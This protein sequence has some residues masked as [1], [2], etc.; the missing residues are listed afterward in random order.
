M[1]KTPNASQRLVIEDLENNA[2]VFAS[3]GT[4]KTFTVAKRVANILSRGLAKAEEILCLTFT[5][6][7]CNEM[8][9][10]ICRYVDDASTAVQVSTIHGFCYKLLLE[11][12]KRTG[13]TYSDLDVCDEVDQEE[14]AK[15]ILSEGYPLWQ[16]EKGLQAHDLSMPKLETLEICRLKSGDEL[17]WK[18]G[19]WLLSTEGTLF[20]LPPKEAFAPVE[21]FC[22]TCK[23]KRVL[24]DNRCEV[25]GSVHTLSL[26]TKEFEV[27][28]K[29]TGLRNL[30][31]ELKH[32]REEA[33]LYT[34][35]AEEDYARSLAYLRTEK[36]AAYE[37]LFAYY[38]PYLGY[39]PDE[40]FEEAM[41]A[42]V[43]KW[44]AT[45]DEYLR[46]SNLLDFDDLILQA[47][48]ILDGEEGF[49]YWS[50]KYK[51]I[52]LDEMQ[53]TS[54]LEYSLLKKIFAKNNVLLCG[55][56]FQTIYGWRGSRPLEILEEYTREFSAK[57]Y[58]LSENY[59]A[60]KTLAEATFG[61]LKNTYPD[62]MG[63]FC[64]QDLR[65]N[66]QVEGEPIF[67]YAFD[68]REQEAW[69]IYKYLLRNKP[70]D[71]L[72]TC[73]I[74]RSN[75]YIAELSAYF[76]RFAT[77]RE[78][79]DN[80]RF[81]T[82]EE[83]V[84]FFKKAVVKDVLAV[85]KLLL[86]PYDRVSMERLA[87]KYVRQV[88]VKTLE[89][90]RQYNE[91]GISVC[92]FIDEQTYLYGDPYF[93]LLE[94][95]TK[96]QIVVYD[97]ETTGL[98]LTKDEIVQLSAIK[99]NAAGETV[100]TID[101]WI[102]PTVPLEEGA[103]RTHGF[104]LETIRQNGGTSAKE[105]L[106]RFADFCKG[107][108]LVG[109]N[110]LSYDRPLLE[111][112]LQEN[113]LPPIESVGEYDTLLIAKQ[114]RPQLENYK[115]GTLC[116]HFSVVNTCAHNALGDIT[117]TGACLKRLVD[118]YI[119]PTALERQTVLA[120]HREKFEKFFAF[121]QELRNKLARREPL[122]S[123]I[124]ERL[125]LTTKYPTHTDRL[126]LRDLIESLETE[127][128][129]YRVFLKEYLK[130]AALSG[131]QMDVLLRKL[132]RIPIITVHQS[133]GCEFD[134]VILAGADDS[135]FP[136]FAAKQSGGEEE[137]KKVFYVAITRAKRKL[138][139]TRAL[140]NGRH[141]VNETPYFWKL[142]EEY[143]RQNRAW[144]NGN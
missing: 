126:A 30:I 41:N 63:K 27:F 45:Y 101:L 133:K 9:E 85:L 109:H 61:Y 141:E 46:L 114:F 124:I 25:C 128:T 93:R 13:N 12:A 70:S 39:A 62:L 16:L 115:L 106:V 97:T 64:P 122:A 22:S 69:Q 116:S 100:D 36:P 11:E 140:R 73:I 78:D 143:V 127:R 107:C 76:Q 123:Y 60:T 68:N 59:R 47:K 103:I 135:N 23:E 71:P 72:Q 83:N 84:Q 108:V 29:K 96:E 3:A 55:D 66:S 121:M 15:R 89:G 80:L 53:D 88:G 26:P 113:D 77:E 138:V 102:E 74:A 37:S 5:I 90:L 95:F 91:I 6:K 104:T 98:D 52:I 112:Q 21:V 40:A 50:K 136:S 110:N 87:E 131:S 10:D 86:N 18:Y 17:F 28:R 19:D 99:L 24:R 139:L 79:K 43:G 49:S 58:M 129:D 7:A 134:T 120:K 92:S 94:G 54:L 144:K 33:G 132:K 75:K 34:Q 8:K 56:F 137:E 44:V 111:R 67:C 31:S 35:N 42:Y 4:G 142:P 2:I 1:S 20:P 32:C 81:F 119:L 105:A 118:G 38:A 48:R 51:Y 125:L 82:V 14:F 57:R 130:D 65:V 117:A